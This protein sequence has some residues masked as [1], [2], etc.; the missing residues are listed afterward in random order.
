MWFEKKHGL[1]DTCLRNQLNIGVSFITAD[2]GY[3]L[4]WEDVYVI[5]FDVVEGWHVWSRGNMLDL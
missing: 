1:N 2:V 5:Y 3:G 4:P